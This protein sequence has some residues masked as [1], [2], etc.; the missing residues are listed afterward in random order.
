[1]DYRGDCHNYN[2]LGEN[3]LAFVASTV[4]LLGGPLGWMTLEDFSNLGDF[5]DSFHHPMCC[6][7]CKDIAST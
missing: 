6:W 1:M 2:L 5:C 3:I 7:N 4:V